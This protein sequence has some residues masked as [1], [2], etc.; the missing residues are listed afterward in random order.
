MANH[1]MN[2]N[3]AVLFNERRSLNIIEMDAASNNSVDDIREITAQVLVPPITGK[4]RVF[5]IDEVHMLSPAAFNAFLKTPPK[6][7]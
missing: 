5:I 7:S 3:P 1:V 4:Y 6:F 2:A